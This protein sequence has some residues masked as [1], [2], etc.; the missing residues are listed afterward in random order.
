MLYNNL[1]E[2]KCAM[3]S[4]IKYEENSLLKFDIKLGCLVTFLGSGNDKIISN[5]T[6]FNNENIL[7]NNIMCTSK[8]FYKIIKYISF[9]RKKEI[10]IFLGETVGDCIAFGLEN[11]AISKKEMLIKINEFSNAFGLTSLLDK[12]P[13][14][15]G[16]SD[17]VKVKIVSALVLKPKV[18]VLDNVLDDLDYDDYLLVTKEIKEYTDN[19]NIVL[20]FTNEIE[21]SLLGSRIIIASDDKIIIDGETILVLKEEKLLKR[22]GIGFPFIIELNSYLLDYGLINNYILDIESLVKHLW[23]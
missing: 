12:D 13:Y 18:L 6:S 20:N 22:L 8:N 19:N 15:L 7:I 16:V 21:H 5:L 4:F 1:K 10:D 3:D 11:K 9:V 17:K 14:S 2:K 23:K